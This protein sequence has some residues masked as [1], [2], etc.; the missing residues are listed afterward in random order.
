[1]LSKAV[2]WHAKLALVVIAAI[3]ILCR[4]SGSMANLEIAIQMAEKKLKPKNKVVVL[5]CAICA[6]TLASFVVVGHS[7]SSYWLLTLC[8]CYCTWCYVISNWSRNSLRIWL[9]PVLYAFIV[10]CCSRSGE[11]R[12]LVYWDLITLWWV[13]QKSRRVRLPSTSTLICLWDNC[14]SRWYRIAGKVGKVFFFGD[15]HWWSRKN[16]QIK[17]RQY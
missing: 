3:P 2:L 16:H 6:H 10:R 17:F 4:R 12:S 1:M 8:V 14:S 5:W 13:L 15:L 9:T 7:R 11:Q